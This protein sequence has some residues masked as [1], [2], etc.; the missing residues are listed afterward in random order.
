MN[1]RQLKY[2]LGVLKEK[3]ITRAAA[4]LYVAQPALGLQI[5]KL[6]EELDIDLFI[7]HSRGVTPTEAGKRLGAHAEI[8]IRQ[9]ERARQDML[10]FVGEPQGQ[11]SVGLPMSTVF[12][13][14]G[15]LVE[16]C[17][18]AHP[19]IRLNISVGLSEHLMEWVQDDRIDLTLTYNA[20]LGDELVLE[21]L[22]KEALFFVQSSKRG[23]PSSADA[24]FSRVMQ[25]DLTLPTRPHMLRILIDDTA[26]QLGLEPQI[27]FEIDSVPAIK[28]IVRA[29]LAC[30][31]LPYGAVQAEVKSGEFHALPVREPVLERTLYLAY[32]PNVPQTKGFTAV[33][34]L[35][36]S[37]VIDTL[38]GPEGGWIPKDAERTG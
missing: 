38:E 6:E 29:D 15:A 30:T 33:T 8:L 25:A 28:E 24:V 21:P 12:S 35:L 1:I 27:G 37:V 31:I 17:R 13:L 22:A 34:D 3:S 36:R 16:R 14:A 18:Q 19:K 2:F 9:F 10:D 4:R 7:R 32:S 23:Q 5:R 26:R 20:N 11:V